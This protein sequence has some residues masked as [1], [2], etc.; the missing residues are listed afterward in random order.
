MQFYHNYVVNDL[1]KEI[2][3]YI[4]RYEDLVNNPIPILTDCF[5]FLLD[6]RDL[7]N[8]MIEKRIRGVAA[9]EIESK[10]IYPLK[11]SALMNKNA[12]MYSDELLNDI[13]MI[14]KDYNLFYG[15]TTIGKTRDDQTSFFA[16]KDGVFTASEKNLREGYKAINLA[17]IGSIDKKKP[18]Q[19]LHYFNSQDMSIAEQFKK[20]QP[21]E[22]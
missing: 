5:K 22:Y 6:V 20:D 17:S 3:T 8:T 4:I 16:Y 1:A 21:A 10:T 11:D 15:Y 12:D 18:T 13:K 2:P 9:L 7:K 19:P 14:L